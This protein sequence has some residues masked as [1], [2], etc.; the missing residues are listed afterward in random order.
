[1]DIYRVLD[2]VIKG[3]KVPQLPFY[4]VCSRHH[5]QFPTIDMIYKT[6]KNISTTRSMSKR[7]TKKAN[8][9]P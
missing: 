6:H 1:M 5:S 2:V 7:I 8:L 4:I 9:L 3:A